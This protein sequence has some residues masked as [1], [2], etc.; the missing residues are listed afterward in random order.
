[1]GGAKSLPPDYF[2]IGEYRRLNEQGR[3]GGLGELG[4]HRLRKHHKKARASCSIVA[5]DSVESREI[6]LC[7]KKKRVSSS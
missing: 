7:T 2:G 5:H 3:K 6:L 1:M 4:I